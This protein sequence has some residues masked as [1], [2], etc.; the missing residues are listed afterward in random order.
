MLG[1]VCAGVRISA[2]ALFYKAILSTPAVS[3]ISARVD[4]ISCTRCF[5]PNA[6]PSPKVRER[7][8]ANVRCKIDEQWDC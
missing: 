3:S 5:C 8:L 6:L 4:V 2:G 7:Q 1:G